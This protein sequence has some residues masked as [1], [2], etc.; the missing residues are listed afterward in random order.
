MNKLVLFLIIFLAFFLRFW[1]LSSTPTSLSHDEVAIGYNAWSILQTGKDEYGISYP[2]LFRSF[3][4]YKLPGYIYSTAISEK[5]FGLNEF[6]VRFPS[7]VLGVLTVIATYLLVRVFFLSR[8]ITQNG[9]RNNAEMMA[10]L[11]SFL[12]AINPWHINFSRAAFETNGSLFFL[13]LGVYLLFLGIRK[14]WFFI[15][16]SISFIISIY[17]YYTV[18]ILI[19]VVITAFIFSYRWELLKVKKYLALSLL[20]GIFLLIP[21]LSQMFSNGLSRV[22]QVSI[23]E[24]K[25][26]TNPYSQAILRNSDSLLAKVFYNRRLAYLQEFSDN[27]FKNFAPDF[28]FVNGT[29]SM[30]LLYL[31]EAPFFFFGIYQ[32]IKL[33]KKWKWVILA[34]FFGVPIVGGLTTGQP[35]ALRTLPNVI[36]AELFTAFGLFS[37]V[38]LLKKK[39]VPYFLLVMIGVI[40]FFFIR[41]MFLYFDYQANLSASNWGDGHKQMVQLVKENKIKYDSIYVTGDYWRP[42]IYTLFYANYNPSLYQKTGSRYNINNIYFGPDSWNREGETDFAKADLS[43]LSKAKTLFLLSFRDFKSQKNLIE[44]KKVPYKFTKVKQ[45]DGNFVKGAFYAVELF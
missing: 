44:E 25:S 10:L 28:F 30:G 43:K 9:T 3:D 40:G 16:S 2:I 4:D 26:L 20:L 13:I 5:I 27:Y 37:V 18:R 21:L 14:P 42:Y 6:A 17:F 36:T 38:N 1:H 32:I 33:K 22:N 41:F 29:G 23:F 19:P 45:I 35:N 39:Y 8:G 7:A 24:D 34:W 11:S 15:L 12:L 31:W